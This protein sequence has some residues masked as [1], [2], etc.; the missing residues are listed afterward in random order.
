[1]TTSTIDLTQTHSHHAHHGHAPSKRAFALHFVE[2]NVSMM[3]G[4]MMGGA[5]GV[6]QVPDTTLKAVLWLVAMTL[7]MV[8]WMRIRGMSWR[9]GAEM[10]LGMAV[11]TA[12]ALV[13]FSTG[14]IEPKAV[15]GIEHGSMIP[16]MLAV[17]LVRRKEYG[18]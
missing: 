5:L 14:L 2:M 17:M 11:P 12:A 18:L 6:N 15:N 3:V 8:G 4:M 13:L 1:M 16:G 7:P 10:S 9:Q